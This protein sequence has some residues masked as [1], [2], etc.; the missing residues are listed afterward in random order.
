MKPAP[1]SSER[2]SAV[3][4]L[5]FVSLI[6]CYMIGP[7]WILAVIHAFVFALCMET[8]R[9]RWLAL[10]LCGFLNVISPH[11]SLLPPLLWQGPLLWIGMKIHQWDIAGDAV[12]TAE[13]SAR[14]AAN[15]RRD[16]HLEMTF[17]LVVAVAFFAAFILSHF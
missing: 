12:E 1:K 2:L 14:I 11:F 9:A 7:V 16:S 13:D 5:A 17:W 10:G 6:F 15:R 4:M 3:L 8:G